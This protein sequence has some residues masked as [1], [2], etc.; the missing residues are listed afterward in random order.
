MLNSKKTYFGSKSEISVYVLD[1]I[2]EIQ[3]YKLCILWI[4]NHHVT[5]QANVGLNQFA[6]Q[7]LFALLLKALQHVFEH[8]V[9]DNI[10]KY[11]LVVQLQP[12]FGRSVVIAKKNNTNFNPL[13]ILIYMQTRS[14]GTLGQ[15]R[16]QGSP[17]Q[18]FVNQSDE[19]STPNS[20]D[21][22]IFPYP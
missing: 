22:S 6:Q 8:L 20:A 4:W 19:V 16:S 7:F 15:R 5:G 10:L 14:H 3:P 13:K 17:H 12:L 1:Q 21:K 11:Y 2:A 18:V 9:M